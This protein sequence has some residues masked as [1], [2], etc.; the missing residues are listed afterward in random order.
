M[1]NYLPASSAKALL[2]SYVFFVVGKLSFDQIFR[3][4]ILFICD[5]NLK[6]LLLKM[7][8]QVLYSKCTSLIV[9]LVRGKCE[10]DNFIHILGRNLNYAN[11]FMHHKNLISWLLHF[12]SYFQRQKIH[13]TSLAF[14]A[15]ILPE[16]IYLEWSH[17]SLLCHFDS[18]PGKMWKLN[19]RP[20]GE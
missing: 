7:V 15:W 9:G 8:L 10:K 11:H 14:L 18:N 4:Y 5:L 19:P 12:V 3:P 2:Q 16:H 17:I 20:R 13:Q 6:I 1:T